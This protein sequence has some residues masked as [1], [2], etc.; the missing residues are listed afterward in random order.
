MRIS[1]QGEAMS[2]RAVTYRA[3]FDVYS[4]IKGFQASQIRQFLEESQWQSP[5]EIRKFQDEN[6]QRLIEYAYQY[7]PYYRRV[8]EEQELKPKDIQTT[9][10]L[11]K[12]PVLT[13]E[14][15]RKN[16]NELISTQDNSFKTAIRKTGGSTGEPLKIMNDNL[17]AAWES[18]AFRRGLGF[19]GCKLGEPIIKLFGG[20]LDLKPDGFLEKIK[21][22]L[23]GVVL[24]PAFEINQDTLA[25]YVKRIRQSKAKFLRGYASAIYL[26]AKLMDKTKFNVSLQGVFPTS[27][28]LYDFQREAIEKTFQCK[29]FNQ[30]GC[31]ECN[32]IAIECE[33]HDGL[34]VS[35]EHVFLESLKG[36]ERVSDGETG[37]LTLTTLHNYTMP[38]IRYQNGDVISLDR[39]QCSCGRGLSRINK[40]HGRANDFLLAKD[41][42]LISPI[43]LPWI[44]CHLDLKGIQ[45]FQVIQE[46]K[47]I[48]RF[49]IVK[50]SEFAENELRSLFEIFH[51]YLGDVKI[52]VEYV[53]FVPRTPQG[54]VK[55][56]I[57]EFGYKL[58]HKENET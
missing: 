11:I 6:V 38:L 35:D 25:D 29:A 7:V 40:I 30:Y 15:F 42:R 53:D 43:F 41:G 39:T 24:L 50:A 44:C 18:A 57:S 46:V 28:T 13:K 48:I 16:W 51:R 56:V 4:R 31:G 10:E 54:K 12:L 20:S 8:M 52:E 9:D 47:D 32:S 58:L 1:T 26:L 33:S 5:V 55:F 3:V 34:H 37:A 36:K 17:N 22:K 49:K 14:N 21:A 2:L 23:S 45:Q 19:A 27:E